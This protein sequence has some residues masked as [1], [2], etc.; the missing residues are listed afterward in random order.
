MAFR[1]WAGLENPNRETLQRHPDRTKLALLAAA[2]R[3]QSNN[4]PAARA[5][6][7]NE[8]KIEVN[9]IRSQLQKKDIRI[10]NLD[11]EL[12]ERDTRQHQLNEELI[13]DVL[14]REP[15]L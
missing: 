8:C 9:Q 6:L 4:I 11:A 5:R 12:V 1:G 15:G 3:L 2:G 13:K 10:A 7:A 14:L